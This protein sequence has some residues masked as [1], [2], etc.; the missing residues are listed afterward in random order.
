MEVTILTQSVSR[1]AGGLFNSVRRTAQSLQSRDDLN[2]SVLGRRDEETAHDIDEWA[3]LD[4]ILPPVWGPKSFG[5]APSLKQAVQDTDPDVLHTQ[6]LWTYASIA[7][8]STAQKID[9]PYVVTPR[10]ML[11]SW[12]IQNSQW[13]KQIASRLFERKHLQNAACLHALC[14][15]EA[16]SI[17]EYGL[18]NPVCIIP[19]G[20]D[21][22]VGNEIRL[23]APWRE[24]VGTGNNVLL[25]LGRIHPKKGL[26]PLI[27]AWGAAAPE[28][29]HLVIVGWDDGGHETELKRLVQN[30]G[31]QSTVHFMGSMYGH[32]KKA[33]FSHADAFI[34]PSY[35]EGL[36]MAVLEAWSYRLPVLMTPE[37]NIPE[38]F[39]KD[40]A[41]RIR[42]DSDSVM[43][44][45]QRFAA[46][47][48]DERMKI[49][50]RGRALVEEKFT[51]PRVAEQMH[52]VYEWILGDGTEPSCIWQDSRLSD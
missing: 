11:D 29:W 15:S 27:E 39:A 49:G 43:R 2:I 6:G 4:P 50:E 47:P 22:P 7:T 9:V 51:W 1:L 10:G 16:K 45:V 44:G 40:A 31:L 3:P 38:G 20:V 25:F 42:P 52:S 34:L 24:Q 46:M 17:R 19:N 48:R 36:P 33:A 37:C 41:V 21:L 32:E 5:Y 14:A 35:S 12:A 8:Y 28:N 18:T 13:K 26:Q 23:S 30:H